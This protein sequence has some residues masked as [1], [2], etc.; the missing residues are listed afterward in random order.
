VSGRGLNENLDQYLGTWYQIERYYSFSGLGGKCWKQTYYSDADVA[1]KSRLRM[2]HH[3]F[4][5]V[6]HQ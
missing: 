6:I 5:L 1:G 4:V 3:D 2:E